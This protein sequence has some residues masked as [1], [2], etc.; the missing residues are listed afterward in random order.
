MG[1]VVDQ[2]LLDELADR[3]ADGAA[4]GAERGGER[5]LAERFALRDATLDD[6]LAELA[7]D[8]LR[9]RRPLDTREAPRVGQRH[10]LLRWTVDNHT[11]LAGRGSRVSRGAA[12]PPLTH[13]FVRL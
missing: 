8:L 10:G 4:A 7:Q 12:H 5:D 9:H 13:K 2:A 11:N 6:R 3:L 1:L